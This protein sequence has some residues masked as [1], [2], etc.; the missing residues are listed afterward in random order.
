MITTTSSDGDPLPENWHFYADFERHFLHPKDAPCKIAQNCSLSGRRNRR[1]FLLPSRLAFPISHRWIGARVC[2]L[3]FYRQHLD[4]HQA[5]RQT[6]PRR[7]VTNAKKKERMKL[8]TTISLKTPNWAMMT[9]NW[10]GHT[11][12]VVVVLNDGHC[13]SCQGIFRRY[14]ADGE[15]FYGWD[16]KLLLVWRESNV[17]EG[18]G[19]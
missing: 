18:C 2:C 19:W 9:L 17:P 3:A 14:D 6:N 15:R 10:L 5:H 11:V 7:P 1:K 13:R 4:T 12:T 8:L 16:A